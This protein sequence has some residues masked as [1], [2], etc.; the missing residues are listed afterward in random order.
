[1]QVGVRRLPRTLSHGRRAVPDSLQQTL[2]PCNEIRSTVEWFP[3]AIEYDLASYSDIP[4]DVLPFAGA[5]DD[6]MSLA[7]PNVIPYV[8][9]QRQ[10]FKPQVCYRDDAYPTI[11]NSGSFTVRT[12]V[13]VRSRTWIKR[14]AFLVFSDQ[15]PNGDGREHGVDFVC[16]ASLC[17]VDDWFTAAEPVKV[18]PI[19]GG[20]NAMSFS[21]VLGIASLASMSAL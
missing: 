1:M 16:D 2:W 14:C 7:R 3:L 21:L 5:F 15:S 6:P 13:S 18:N 20:A 4:V 10:D 9:L 8:I 17:N 12:T 11:E 19:D